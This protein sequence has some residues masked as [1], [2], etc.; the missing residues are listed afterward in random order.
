MPDSLQ[1]L[2][3]EQNL[4]VLLYDVIQHDFEYYESSD[5]YQRFEGLEAC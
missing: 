5:H 4:M 1:V 2:G 3:K